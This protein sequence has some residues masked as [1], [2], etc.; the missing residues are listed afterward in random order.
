MKSFLFGK[1]NQVVDCVK[2]LSFFDRY[3]TTAEFNNMTDQLINIDVEVKALI[4]YTGKIAPTQN[5]NTPIYNSVLVVCEKLK[6]KLYVE[7][8]S[9]R[10]LSEVKQLKH[11]IRSIICYLN[12]ELSTLKEICYHEEQKVIQAFIYKFN[13]Y[14]KSLS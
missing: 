2:Y 5:Y 13:F 3:L 6:R 11:D 14:S 9:R 10:K 7:Y 12:S 8:G 4:A 1:L